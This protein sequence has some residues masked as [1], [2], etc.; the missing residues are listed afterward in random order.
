MNP[1]PT[2]PSDAPAPDDGPAAPD[3][4]V[5]IATHNRPVLLREALAAVTSQRYAGT[6]RCIVVFDRSEPDETLRSSD[7][8]RPV[9]IV[10]NG[11]SPG[12][13][14]ARNTG[15]LA[16][17]AG[18]VAFCDDDDVWHPDKL[19]HQVEAMTPDG[20]PT[21]VT[22]IEIDYEGRLT[23]RVP[24]PADLELRN[25][26]RNRVMEAHPSTV[27]VRRDALLTTIGLVDEDIPG[28]YG[29]DFDWMIRA[30]GAGG[31]EVVQ[32]PLVRVRWGSS[33][34]STQWRT[35]VD[36]IDYG[37]AKHA[38]FHEDRRA[39]ARLY[40]RKAFALAALGSSGAL[41]WS[42]RS[43]AAS[44]RERRA[45]LAAAVALHLV[46]AERLLDLAHRRGHGI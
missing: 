35:I 13:A 40:G 19:R 28:S 26:V 7:T 32:E 34:F 15:I 12:L 17:D 27:L 6:I 39:L 36:A 10:T 41:R 2:P 20:P 24:T 4:D 38:V 1:Q 5:V 30:A 16:G 44:P 31:F 25:L 18:L 46:S 45:Y 21:C 42:F 9:E 37:L 11:R 43:A 14:G 23:E 29:E 33:L 8:H 22:G 3:V